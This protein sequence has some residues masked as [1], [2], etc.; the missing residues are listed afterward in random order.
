MK[1]RLKLSSLTDKP[2][3]VWSVLFIIAPLIMVAYYALTD[4]TGAFSLASVEQIPTYITTILLSVLYGLAATVICLI[5]GFPFAY[6]FSKAPKKYQ[7]L[8]VLL[9][10]LPMWM[11][12]LI[13]TYS[14]MT[15]LGDSGVIN[16]L[17]SKLGLGQLELINNG[18]AVILGMVYNFLPYMILPIFSVLTKMDNSLVEAAQDLGSN[19]LQVMKRVVI[20]LSVPGILSGITMVFVPCVS[21][22][23]ITQK[24]GGGQVVL[25]GDVIE[26]QFQSANNY[27]LGAALSFVLMI[28][29]FICL[30][31][32]N[33]FGAD[34]D[35]DGGVVI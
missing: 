26:T 7:N 15:I 20:P 23:Y 13:R 3:L 17:L 8:V 24:L 4:R 34:D 14:W 32:M 18:A 11:N 6:I 35:S 16:T 10:M 5:L 9:V 2:Y 12:F 29:I 19:K 31:I 27:N 25:I 33:Y 22:F 1:K 30:G 21:T 28:L